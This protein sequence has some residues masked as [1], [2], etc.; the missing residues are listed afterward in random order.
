MLARFSEYACNNQDGRF[1]A[2]TVL[3]GLCRSVGD[4]TEINLCC[5][6]RVAQW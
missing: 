6:R 4:N 2:T 1:L 5:Y 3:M